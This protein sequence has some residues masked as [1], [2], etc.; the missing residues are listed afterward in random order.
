MIV[1]NRN[2]RRI[3]RAPLHS[4]NYRA[5][6]GMALAY[7]LRDLPANARRFLTGGGEYPYACR[8]RTP[9]GPVAPTLYSNHDIATVNEIFARKDYRC[10][11]DLRVAV[12]MGANIGI[13]ALYFLTRNPTARVYAFE[14]NPRNV[15]RL[16]ENLAGY[17]SRYELE[18]VAI[19]TS[20]GNA[21]FAADPYG[22][23]GT[24]LYTEDTWYEPTFIDV[25]VREINSVL[26]AILERE[27]EIDILKIDTEGLE[28]QLV[29]ALDDRVLA[30]IKSIVYETAEPAPFH[31]DRFSYSFDCQTNHLQA[32]PRAAP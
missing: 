31:T 6:L 22:R 1:G 2:V 18:E 25:R 21:Q 16:R 32:L 13:S 7:P 3:V 24:L 11:R 28:E 29:G 15:G 4:A 12:D 30:Q 14:P 27:H 5:A 10:G 9:S 23:Y 19:G 17:E 20:D 26:A 8:V